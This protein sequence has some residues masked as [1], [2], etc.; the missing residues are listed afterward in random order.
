MNSISKKLKI[1]I[2]YAIT[3][4]VAFC[5][6]AY[7]LLLAHT[8]SLVAASTV[9]WYGIV[10]GVFLGSLG[11]GSFFVGK[12]LK[13]NQL[14]PLLLKTELLLTFIGGLVAL[15]VFVAHS[16]DVFLIT[17]GFI[18]IGTTVFIGISLS[19]VM[20]VGL[21][22]GIELPLLMKIGSKEAGR[23][24]GNR[25][26]GVDYFGSLFGSIIFSVLLV[27]NMNVIMI[28]F[29]L[30]CINFAAAFLLLFFFYEKFIKTIEYIVPNILLTIF[31]AGGFLIS[32]AIDMYFA[33]KYYY[34][35]SS[36]QS[37]RSL[38]SPLNELPDIERTQ[39]PYQIID[40]VQLKEV[41]FYEEMVDL[42]IDSSCKGE[43]PLGDLE[44]YLNGDWQLN[45]RTEKAY[46][47]Y[48]AHVPIQLSGTVPKRI[49]VLGGGDGML[50][51][52]LLKYDQVEQ[53]I[54]VD[55]DREMIKLATNGVLAQINENSLAD[56]RVDVVIADGYS[57]VKNANEK[58]DAI[59]IDFPT[60]VDYNLARLYSREFYSFVGKRIN[61]GGF[62][63]YDTPGIK[64][65][66]EFNEE[67]DLYFTQKSNVLTGYYDTIKSAGFKTVIPFVSGFE[68]DNEKALLVSKDKA[69]ERQ[70]NRLKMQDKKVKNS[71]LLEQKAKKEGEES[72]REFA[73]NILEG[74]IFA[75]KYQHDLKFGYKENEIPLCFLNKDRFEIS[76]NVPFEIAQNGKEDNINSIMKPVLPLSRF[77][78]VRMPYYFE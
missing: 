48:F 16:L 38:I 27:P 66:L 25:I 50:D 76:T 39:S 22:S 4:L 65:L 71:Y 29:S 34:F 26:L 6:I 20:V 49:L 61:D 15:L 42:Y 9:V 24:L 62:V 51:R 37:F 1:S 36:S 78:Q 44:L 32:P 8:I 72:V 30:A 12:L 5:S 69:L 11:V 31:V 63:A 58:F 43:T 41:G 35:I 45:I 46:H 55:L 47:E 75:T 52:E 13:K 77:W 18:G 64:S 40:L 3:F 74:F 54:H 53:I 59:F 70:L 57:F 19:G 10:I 7:E 33:K 73:K 17:R 60:P 21:L 56:R 68:I 23:D 28:G 2:I 14:Y 67:G